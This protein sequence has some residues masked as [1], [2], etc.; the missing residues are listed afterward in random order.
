MKR[1]SKKLGLRRN[2]VQRVRNLV[3]ASIF[4][5]LQDADTK[6]YLVRKVR[7]LVSASILFDF[8]IGRLVFSIKGKKMQR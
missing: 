6:V 3:S 2:K 5:S 4:F 1:K 7:N 8:W